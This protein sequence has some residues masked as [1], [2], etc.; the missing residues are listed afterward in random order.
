M[1]KE[2]VVQKTAKFSFNYLKKKP[3]KNPPK[4]GFFPYHLEISTKKNKGGIS[5]NQM[6]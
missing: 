2:L 5:S 1:K 4:S 3:Q 6:H